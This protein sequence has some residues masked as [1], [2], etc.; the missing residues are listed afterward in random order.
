LIQEEN[1][2]VI[3]KEKEKMRKTQEGMQ[4]NTVQSVGYNK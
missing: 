3:Y 4:R 1:I 2:K